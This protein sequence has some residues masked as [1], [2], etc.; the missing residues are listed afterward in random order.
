[1]NA[2]RIPPLHGLLAFEALARRIRLLGVRAATLVRARTLPAAATAA[3][4]DGELF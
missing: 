4:A 3:P 2:A 1:M